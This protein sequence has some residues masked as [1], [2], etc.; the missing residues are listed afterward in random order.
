MDG[1]LTKDVGA[2]MLGS[3]RSSGG[4][5]SGPDCDRRAQ[6]FERRPLTAARRSCEVSFSSRRSISV[7]R[8]TA[9]LSV[10]HWRTNS[11]KN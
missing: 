9:V 11:W 2:S 1:P 6:S 4:A 8:R 10:R 5:E 7:V 3:V